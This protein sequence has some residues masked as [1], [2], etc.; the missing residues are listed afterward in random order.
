MATHALQ[1]FVAAQII[2]VPL[3]PAEPK[4][5]LPS[6]KYKEK[7]QKHSH[8]SITPKNQKHSRHSGR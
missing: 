5:L 6:K 7:E 3:I 8:D 4:V 2:G 1:L